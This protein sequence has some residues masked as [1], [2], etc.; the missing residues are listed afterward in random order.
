MIEE[1]WMIFDMIHVIMIEEDWMIF[2]IHP[3]VIMIEED[4]II[5]DM[6]LDQIHSVDLDHH[7]LEEM[8]ERL[9]A[10]VETA[11]VVVEVEVN[12]DEKEEDQH[13][14]A[15]YNNQHNYIIT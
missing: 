5:L 13:L 8:I 11:K 7:L 1:D 3:Q 9:K 2:D 6:I 12:I 14:K 10:K 15:H 4:W